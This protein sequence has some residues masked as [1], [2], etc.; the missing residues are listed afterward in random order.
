[1]SGVRV[2][3][4][5]PD[6]LVDTVAEI[7]AEQDRDQRWHVRTGELT[8][9]VIAGPAVVADAAVVEMVDDPLPQRGSEDIRLRRTGSKRRG[10][11]GMRRGGTIKDA[12]QITAVSA[13]VLHEDQRAEALGDQ[14][15]DDGGLVAG[16]LVRDAQPPGDLFPGQFLDEPQLVDLLLPIGEDSG[17]PV[18]TWAASWIRLPAIATVTSMVSGAGATSSCLL[19]AAG[20]ALFIGFLRRL[21]SGDGG[22]GRAGPSFPMPAESF[23]T[24]F[25]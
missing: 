8:A 4:D 24:Y 6:D 9:F 2:L 11:S 16:G 15:L 10:G 25:Q 1:V 20:A 21:D 23:F 19:L 3:D 12:G 13:S 7:G 22:L 14:A 18:S 5:A 17:D